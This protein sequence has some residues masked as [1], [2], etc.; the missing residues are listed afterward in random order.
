MR[1]RRSLARHSFTEHARCFSLSVASL[2]TTLTSLVKPPIM[3]ALEELVRQR[4]A[5]IVEL[6]RLNAEKETRINE[7][8]SQLDKYKSVPVSYTHLTLPTKRIV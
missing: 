2:L 4:D 1:N 8:L 3:E 5:Q 7:L 6:E